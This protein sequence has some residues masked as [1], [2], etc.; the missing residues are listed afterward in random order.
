MFK[1]YRIIV[2]NKLDNV[3]RNKVTVKIDKDRGKVRGDERKWNDSNP[4]TML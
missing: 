1:Q 2:G 4:F 3:R